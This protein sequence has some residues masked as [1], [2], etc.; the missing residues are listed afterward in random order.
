MNS[1]DRTV[2]FKY[3]L[4]G[5]FVTQALKVTAREFAYAT[6]NSPSNTCSLGYGTTYLSVYTP[7]THPDGAAVQAG[8]GVQ[9]T[10]VTESFNPQPPAG[11]ITGG[12]SL[13]ANSEFKDNLSYCRSSPLT[14]S[15]SVTQTISIETFQVR[16]NKITYSS[17]GISLSSLGPTQ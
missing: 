4:S 3:T 9:G 6:N 12:G 7:Y 16:Q 1:Q 5:N 13:D 10:P 14:P 11:T 2:T 15:T 17:S 8:I